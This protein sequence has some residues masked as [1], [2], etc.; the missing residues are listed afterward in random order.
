MTVLLVL[1]A[2]HVAIGF[3]AT[4]AGTA[5][6]QVDRGQVFRF[7]RVQIG[8]FFREWGAWLLMPPLMALG[9]PTA[10]VPRSRT[11]PTRNPV[12]LV[13]G[14]ALNRGTMALLAAFLRRRGWTHVHSINNRPRSTS[15]PVYARH[16][17]QVVD[18]LRRAT[19]ATKVDLVGHSM[20][21]IISAFYV[22]RMGGAEFVGRI[23]TMGTPWRG[24]Q[25]HVWGWRRQARDLR[26]GS[27][28]I[29]DIQHPRVPSVSIWSEGDFIVHPNRH[30]V[31]PGVRDIEL[32]WTGHL[33][34][35]LRPKVWHT[36]AQALSDGAPAEAHGGEE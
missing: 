13:P 6:N 17:S 11:P 22:N 3:V 23:V 15:L 33:E 10:P 21:G 35:L 8:C 1:L 12:I 5:V 14:Y 26:P 19:G 4:L 27:E 30:A 2:V 32:P 18:E 24:T 20:G 36:V 34:M 29:A 16:L 25:M 7:S 9:I 28:V 31:A